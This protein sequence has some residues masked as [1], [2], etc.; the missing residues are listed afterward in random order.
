MDAPPER[1]FDGHNDTLLDLHLPD[2]GRGRSFFERSETG[3]V[4]LPRAREG[5][6]AGGFFAV[7]V[8]NEDTQDLTRTD[9]GYEVPLASPVPTARAKRFTYDVLAQ[10]YSVEKGS[11]GAFSVVRTADELEEALDDERVV[12]AIAHLEGAAAVEPDLSNLDLLYAAGV[13]SIGLTWSRPNAFGHGVP[14][15]YPRSPDT[16][17]G[18]TENGREL[19]RAC[20]ERGIVVDLAHLNE[21]GFRDVADLSDAP[22]VVSHAGTHARCP[23][24]RNLTDAQLADVGATN[25]VVGVP[26]DLP[27]IRP[28]GENDPETPLSVYVDHVEYIADQVGVEHVALGSDFDGCRVP[29]AVGDVTG[30]PCVMREIRKR[31][32][33]RGDLRRFARTN[34]LRVIGE[35]WR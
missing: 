8:P 18:L 30:L 26:F 7:F 35:T 1:V 28:D 24:T 29:N 21:A 12:A 11:N 19:V 14:F 10:L 20:N 9:D 22:L 13:R 6:Y 15:Q 5:N 16:G 27:N 32:F 3:H 25:G 17:P 31:G 2:R 33:S 4:D 23:S 34:W